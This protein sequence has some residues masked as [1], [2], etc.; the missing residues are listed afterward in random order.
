MPYFITNDNPACSGW[1]VE[2]DD[3][4]V[5]GCHRTRRDAIEQMVAVSIDEGIEP[6][7][8]RSAKA[9]S[10]G[11]VTQAMQDEAAQGIEWRQEYGRGGTEVGL[12]TARRIVANDVSM[13]LAVKM[14]AYFARHE[15][16][17]EAAGWNRGEPGYPS[18]GLV[19]WK[20]WGGDSGRT[21]A[22]RVVGEME[23]GERSAGIVLVAGPPAAGKST[24]VREHA[25]DG[26]LVVEWE[27]LALAI[28]PAAGV[29]QGEP[30]RSV[31]GDVRRAAI[32]AI[33]K[34]AAAGDVRAWVVVGAPNAEDRHR[35]ADEI[36]ASS[37]V[38]VLCS[39]EQAAA[40]I[41]DDAARSAAGDE[42][43]G[44]VDRWWAKYTPHRADSVVYTGGIDGKA[45]VGTAQ[46]MNV[47][48]QVLSATWQMKGAPGDNGEA[49]AVVSVFGNKDLV[50]DRVMPGAFEESLAWYAENG[51]SIPWVWSHQWDDPQ[52]YIGKVVQARETAEGLEVKAQFFDTPQA[53]QVRRLL[54]EG[55][56]TE[57]SFAYD[58]VSQ[59]PGKDGV[60]ELRKLHILEVGPTLKGANPATRLVGVRSAM[61]AAKAEP[62]ELQEGSFVEWAGGYGRVE[63]IMTEGF[64]G[65]DGDP[66]SLEASA[67]DPLALVR[68]YDNEGDQW[69]PSDK[70][71]GHRFSMLTA[72]DEKAAGA[73]IDAKAT[74]GTGAKSGRVLSAKNED[75]IRDAAELLSEVL[76]TLPADDNA[77][78]EEPTV[79]DEPAE[80]PANTG[81]DAA[82]AQ[83][84]LE[85]E[86]AE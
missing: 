44:A 68:E 81:M 19:A 77:K 20:L 45:A 53:Q 25:K 61:G 16:D 1:A 37:V 15:V 40:R 28:D 46:P 48:R 34:H 24:Y 80:S 29:A 14:R 32:A 36:G 8:E 12:G 76:G 55:V 52:A 5:I 9:G 43:V 75:R 51:K 79:K 67:E 30:L 27:R 17:Q 69:L 50:G 3:G 2:K 83:L 58:V 56:V 26:D 62:G 59:S 38:V 23:E 4:E 41:A 13:D 39:R 54:A 64:F 85:L 78:S 82:T 7:G 65:V 11:D 18:A 49:T 57:F 10:A 6:G 66:L 74:A 47:K 33:A 22:E 70:F 21:W 86:T 84:L 63:Y 60:N 35:L 71:S 31:V 73:D 42:M 72:T